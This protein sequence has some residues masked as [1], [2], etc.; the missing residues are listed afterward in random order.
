MSSRTEAV[1]FAAVMERPLYLFP[2]WQDKYRGFST[3]QDGE[4]CPAPVEMTDSF[5]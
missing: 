1:L 5:A 3:A 4:A 2:V